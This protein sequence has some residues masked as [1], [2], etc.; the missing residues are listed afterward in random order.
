MIAS[1]PMYA[2]PELDTAH[3]RFWTLIRGQLA[4]VGIESPS[5]L[6][7]TAEEFET[8][9]DPTLVLS[10]T[11][12]MPYRNDLHGNVTLIGAPDYRLEDC[13]PG[14][15]RSAFIVRREDSRRTVAEFASSVFSYNQN[16]SQSG[17]AAAYAHVAALGF[18]FEDCYH[19]G[20][21][22]ESALA[23]ADSR[24]DIA[25]IDAVTWRLI[26]RYE[27]CA[28][29][30][31]VIDYTKPHPGLPYISSAHAPR[32]LIFEAVTQAIG[33]LTVAD[34]D[35]LGIY[36]LIDIGVDAYLNVPNPPAHVTASL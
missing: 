24:A 4:D 31:E 5:E 17:Y 9:N 6:S 21:H 11:C 33:N 22:L 3:H 35:L 19:S 23:V 25:S 18:W 16:H 1:L 13:D 14:W 7:Q 20:Q 32:D 26:E 29:D 28:R 2:R 15:G 12:G 8:W 30:L 10:Q 34:Q 27:P 36:G